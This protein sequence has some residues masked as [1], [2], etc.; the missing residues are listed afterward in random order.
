MRRS[1]PIGGATTSSKRLVGK[2]VSLW[3]VL[4][5]GMT[6]IVCSA[7]QIPRVGLVR[8]DGLG[9]VSLILAMLKNPRRREREKAPSSF[10]LSLKGGFHGSSGVNLQASLSIK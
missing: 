4:H 3:S 9:F 7:S 1:S 2:D 5:H 10:E 6:S 8:C